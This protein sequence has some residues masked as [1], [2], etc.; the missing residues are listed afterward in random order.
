[1]RLTRIGHGQVQTILLDARGALVAA[2]ERAHS[3]PWDQLQPCSPLL[4]IASA[5]HQRGPAHLFAS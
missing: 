5:R 2:V 3:I 1:M 4:D